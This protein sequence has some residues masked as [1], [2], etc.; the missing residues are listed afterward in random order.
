M[1][2]DSFTSRD[3]VCRRC[4][5]QGRTCCS[6]GAEET[7]A[8]SPLSRAELRRILAC[9]S[10]GDR[11]ETPK[12]AFPAVREKNS[13]DFMAA[14]QRL[15]P[16]EGAA[17]SALFPPEGEHLRLRLTAGG[18]CF[19]LTASGCS[20]PREARPG[21]CRIFPFWVRGGELGFFEA[22]HCL[23]I[24]ENASFVPLLRAFALT[25]AGVLEEYARLRRD[26]GMDRLPGEIALNP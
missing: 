17:L 24:R 9:R 22:E 18:D 1:M 13:P 8:C 12:R 25:R 26:W 23:A 14:V 4:A 21:F 20:L 5:A 6:L 16:K 10:A 2:P 15:F 19:F 3:Y 7:S 11:E